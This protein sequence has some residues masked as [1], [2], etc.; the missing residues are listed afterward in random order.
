MGGSSGPSGPSPIQETQLA[1]QK[2]ALRKKQ[3]KI[4]NQNVAQ[5]RAASSEG[6]LLRVVRPTALASPPPA[7]PPPPVRRREPPFFGRGPGEGGI[8]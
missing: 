8:F 3:Q 2:A 5:L 7:A 6:D 1:Q 4:A